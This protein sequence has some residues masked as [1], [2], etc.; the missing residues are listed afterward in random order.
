[1]A[2]NKIAGDLN[3]TGAL[4]A[5][6]FT[7]PDNAVTSDA[8][9]AAGADITRAKNVQETFS[10]F[11]LRLYDARVWDSGALLPTA[12]AANDD[13]WFNMG[14]LGSS[15][16]PT[17]ETEDKASNG[18]AE[19]QS[20]AWLFYAPIEYDEDETFEVRVRAKMQT[21]ADTTMT[22]DCRVF[23]CTDGAVGADLCTTA[24]KTLTASYAN[25]DFTITDTNIAVGDAL[26]IIIDVA[27]QDNATPS[28]VICDISDVRVRCDTRG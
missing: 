27:I 28:G 13:L 20:C 17:I 14:T 3:V 2:V 15:E 12:T 25:Y 7:V 8:K 4:T 16:A 9:I 23:E 1:M 19:T 10:P 22:V 11:P 24:A 26:L 18:A 6:S 5:G 21:V